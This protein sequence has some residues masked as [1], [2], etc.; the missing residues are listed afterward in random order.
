MANIL[1]ALRSTPVITQLL[2]RFSSPY[3]HLPLPIPHQCRAACQSSSIIQWTDIA[4]ATVSKCQMLSGEALTLLAD[5][6]QL[7]VSSFFRLSIIKFSV[8]F[9]HPLVLLH[10]WSDTLSNQLE[11]PEPCPI[12][13]FL[14]LHLIDVLSSNFCVSVKISWEVSNCKGLDKKKKKTSFPF[15]SDFVSCSNGK[16]SLIFA[17][18]TI[19]FRKLCNHFMALVQLLP[20]WFFKFASLQSFPKYFSL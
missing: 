16:L 20:S 19:M 15:T 7:V 12:F 8:P 2:H 14:I 1:S 5:A 13:F 10:S 4:W 9:S 6:A 3:F 17:I 11:L 18:P